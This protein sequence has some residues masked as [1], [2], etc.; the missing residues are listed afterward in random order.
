MSAR[1]GGDYDY[2][3]HENPAR[4]EAEEGP[5]RMSRILAPAKRAATRSRTSKAAAAGGGIAAN[6]AAMRR[7]GIGCGRA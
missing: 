3:A 7:G 2:M 6:G 5:W 4:E 1:A